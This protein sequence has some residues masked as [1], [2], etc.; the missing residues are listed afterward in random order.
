[1]DVVDKPV[2]VP[3]R[4]RGSK[5]SSK[6]SNES[7]QMLGTVSGNNCSP[8]N[9]S[10]I[11]HRANRK[12]HQPAGHEYSKERTNVKVHSNSLCKAGSPGRR[13]ITYQNQS[14]KANNGKSDESDRNS[15]VSD[16][17]HINDSGYAEI[18]LSNER[19]ALNSR[20]VS[21]IGSCGGSFVTM[22]GTV[23]RGRKKGQTM[24]MKVQMSREELDELE[25][26]I[27]SQQIEDDERCFFGVR[28]GPHVL[29]LSLILVPVV[30]VLS[31]GY[32]FYMGTMTWYNVLVYFSEK[33]TIFHKIC[34]SPLLIISYPFLITL[35]TVGLGIYA[36][37][38]QI[39]WHFD[40]WRRE[41]Q[42]WE[43]GFYGWLCGVVHLEDCSPYEVVILTEVL[44]PSDDVKQ[45]KQNLEDTAL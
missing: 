44:P 20:S 45:A 25:H 18:E 23:K 16:C 31:A 21:S 1:M 27:L 35:S 5:S 11:D 2:F 3:P 32:S 17:I 29:T 4:K 10:K 33:K 9:C 15:D 13:S 24:D 26:S 30:L 34:V 19:S 38:V 12:L 41:I 43:K 40:T 28:K 14:S 36:A 8:Q 39:S 37:V 42:D 6:S 7:L 22:T